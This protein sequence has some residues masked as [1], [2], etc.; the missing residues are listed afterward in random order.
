MTGRTLPTAACAS[1]LA[2]LT[3]CLA[4]TVRWGGDLGRTGPLFGWYALCWAL[5]GA[6]VLLLRRVPAR[7]VVPLV[8]AGGL[9][10]AV[11][12][13][14]APPRTSDDSYRYA[15]D[16]RVQ[17][18]GISPYRDTPQ[19]PALARLRDPWLFPTGTPCRAWDLHPVPGGCTRINRPDV[20][21]IYPPVAEGWFGAVHALAP[22]TARHKAVQVGG[23]LAAQAT[24]VVLL[25][26]VGRRARW[27][28]AL[29]AWC[30]A[31]P[32]EAVNNAHVDVVGALPVVAG[33]ALAGAS[34]RS[35]RPGRGRAAAAGVLLGAATAVKLLP[36]L[37][38]P[39]VLSGVLRRGAGGRRGALLTAGAAVAAFAL[40]YLP[41]VLSDGTAVLG[42]LPGYLHEEGYDD[43]QLQR[44][45]LLRL[46]LPDAVAQAAA[47]AA[48]AAAVAW[49]LLRGDPVR[50]WRGALLV[51]GTA[52]LALCPGYPWYAL[53]LVALVAL[54][55]RWE[56]LGVPLAGTVLYLAGGDPRIQPWV[57]GAALAAVLTG[58]AVRSRWSGGGGLPTGP[59]RRRSQGEAGLRGGDEAPVEPKLV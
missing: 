1:V 59:R 2:L 26:A 9:L 17:A 4:V 48:V 24:T 5:F 16:G 28:A 32:L 12:G 43:D 30:P 3:C 39:G 50:P 36:G 11:T 23:V 38:V 40:A 8:A 27:R 53:L 7:R 10:L 35:G 44:F 33:L 18:A 42:Y 45:A 52:F 56:W 25:L 49:V 20:H 47:G 13:L 41:F 19:D 22:A 14:V 15:W 54:D 31:V 58:A 46:V 29:W 6:A 57:Y 21:T 51:T 34:V 37:A 55:G